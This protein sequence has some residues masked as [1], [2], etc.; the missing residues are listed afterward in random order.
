MIL[1]GTFNPAENKQNATNYWWGIG[2]QILD[3]AFSKRFD[4]YAARI[5][6]HFS[7]ELKEGTFTPL[8]RKSVV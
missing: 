6:H 3:V 1:K 5:I 2:S 7:Q 8:D 4:P